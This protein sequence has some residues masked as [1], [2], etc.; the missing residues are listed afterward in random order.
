MQSD[1]IIVGGGS[2][3]CVLAARL[4]ERADRRVLLIDAGHR[5]GGLYGRMPAGSYKLLNNPR[6][7]WMYGTEP[8]PS[9]DNRSFTWP[10]GRL[11]GGGSAINGLVYTRGARFDYDDWAATGCPGWSFDEIEPYF[12]RAEH[13]GGEQPDGLD[14][15]GTEG[16]QRLSQFPE[17]LPIT[18]AFIEACGQAGLPRKPSYCDGDPEGAFHTLGTIANGERWSTARSYLEPAIGRRNLEV[19]SECLVE[20]VLVEDGAAV[21]VRVRRAG[22]TIEVRARHVVLSA[23]TMMSPV[24]LMRSGI[25]AAGHLS[26]LGIPVVN[27][28]PGVGRNLQEHNGS[29]LRRYVAAQTYNSAIRPVSLA[30]HF[31]NYLFNRRG[32]LTSISVHAMAWAKSRPDVPSPDLIYSFLPISFGEGVYPGTPHR[33]HGVTFALNVAKPASRGEIRL[34][35]ADPSSRPLIDHRLLSDEDLDL[36]VIGLD[37]LRDILAQPA[38]ASLLQESIDPEFERAEGDDL[39]SM[40]R[41]ATGTGYHPVGTCRMGSDAGAVVDPSLSVRGLRGLY[42]ADASIMPRITSGNT[43]GPTIAIAEKASDLIGSAMA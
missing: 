38:L 14:V 11:L 18:Q 12:R 6:A 23:G 25:G 30:R 8:D 13:F 17:P 2:A 39:K 37:K 43:N 3:G 9:A 31:A 5:R 35:D 33:R 1:V 7:D 24:I 34:R 16:P 29:G 27:D 26:S 32:P 41:A 15:L 22:Q 10:A 21:G 42:V 28:L 36:L 4:S 19:L 20:K 40:L